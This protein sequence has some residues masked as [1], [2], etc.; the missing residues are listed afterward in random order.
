MSSNN[1]VAHHSPVTVPNKK[2]KSS[3]RFTFKLRTAI[4]FAI[5]I[6]TLMAA[7]VM[8]FGW[9]LFVTRELNKFVGVLNKEI[10]RSLQRELNS[11]FVQAIELQENIRNVFQEGTLDPNNPQD[12]QGLYMAAIAPTEYTWISYG[13]PNGDFFGARQLNPK[14]LHWVESIWNETTSSASRN[15][16]EFVRTPEG[17]LTTDRSTLT[18]S[19]YSPQ[20]S[21]FRLASATTGNIWTP[22]YI[23]STSGRPGI[24]S[25]IAMYDDSGNIEGVI[26]VAIELDQISDFLANLE[27]SENGAILI[28]NSNRQIVAFPDKNEVVISNEEFFNLEYRFNPECQCWEF[29]NQAQ[30]EIKLRDIS[31]GNDTLLQVVNEVIQNEVINLETLDTLDGAQEAVITYGEEDYLVAF[32]QVAQEEFA[33][34]AGSIGNS[35]GLDDLGWYVGA[36]IPSEDILGGIQRESFLLLSII[37]SA[38]VI[39]III[40]LFFSNRL[41][42]KPINLITKQADYIRQFK[43]DLVELPGS[44]VREISRLIGSIG[45]MN[46]GLSSFSRYVPT[47]LV[48]RLITQGIEARLG[49]EINEISIFFC[50]I[51]GFTRISEHMG[52]KIVDHL[53]KYFTHLS[54]I[55]NDCEG[56]IDKYIGDAIMAFWGAPL[57]QPDH[58]IS[59]CRAA[60]L[61]ERTLDRLRMEWRSKGQQEL[62]ARYGVNTGH[63]L[64]GNFGSAVRMSYT[65]IGDPVNVAARLE[66]LNKIYGTQILIGEETLSKI[67]DHFVTRHVDRVAV[68][69]RVGS[70]EVYELVGIKDNDYYPDDYT[71]IKHFE[72]GLLLY[73][74]QK[75]SDAAKCFHDTLQLRDKEDTPSLLF[76]QRCTHLAKQR[77][78]EDWDAT[79]VLKNK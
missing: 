27:I 23:F 38:I 70:M 28:I 6:S 11:I 78:P 15:I 32:D 65:A 66:A 72:E 61:C 57:S 77:I 24:N 16:A 58:A 69:G 22:I 79:F 50:D 51:S 67:D 25:A 53:D 10:I 37:Y 17:F 31:Q 14:T 13:K 60:L 59:A 71:W 56:T 73:R 41:I 47:E 20:R 18:N 42:I 40:V 26:T 55:I 63:V 52:E 7:F 48:Q 29:E 54:Q 75:W 35:R 30:S 46:S 19:Y 12:I 49:G 62:Y 68:Y 64:V 45:R 8:H 74:Q 36:V 2:E 76:I 33:T 3:K 44:S 34:L 43:L 39:F 1:V 4:V 5:L 21:W 9:R